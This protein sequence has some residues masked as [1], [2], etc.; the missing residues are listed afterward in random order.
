VHTHSYTYKHTHTHT[1]TYNYAHTHKHTHTQIENYKITRSLLGRQYNII[2]NGFNLGV[3]QA[4]SNLPAVGTRWGGQPEPSEPAEGELPSA[5]LKER[6]LVDGLVPLIHFESGVFSEY[7]WF[8]KKKGYDVVNAVGVNCG[9][10]AEAMAYSGL[11]DD[12]KLIDNQKIVFWMHHLYLHD[13]VHAGCSDP[14]ADEDTSQNTVYQEGCG[15]CV[16]ARTEVEKASNFRKKKQT[17]NER[18]SSSMSSSSF[19]S[20][21]SSSD[22]GLDQWFVGLSRLEKTLVYDTTISMGYG[23]NSKSDE[24]DEE[25]E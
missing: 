14:T 24:D 1:H 20:M 12:A 23:V 2:V 7:G 9:S 11:D 17:K 8:N 3:V 4:A 13:G 19:S 18:S 10:L 15:G 5:A 6:K 16:R 21:S 25:D 22:D